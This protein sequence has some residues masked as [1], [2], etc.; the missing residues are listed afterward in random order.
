[1]SKTALLILDLQNGILDRVPDIAT[2]L[3]HYATTI[4]AARSASVPVIY[5]KLGFRPNHPDISPRNKMFERV[6][7]YGGFLEGS[8][9]TTIHPSIA[10][11][12]GDIIVTKRRVSAFAG[13]DLELVL[14]SLGVEKLVLAGL[15]TSGVVLSTVR[16]ASDLDYAVTVLSDLCFDSDEEVHK[17]LVE[18][19]FPK[20]ADVTTA[21]EWVAGL[22][23]VEE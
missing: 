2:H 14:R 8:D 1:M 23:A 6:K 3:P 5:V 7:P 16:Q 22:K 13:S 12:D 4:A 17:I 21:D 20:Q 9:A 10:P 18:R 19:I 11:T 15:S